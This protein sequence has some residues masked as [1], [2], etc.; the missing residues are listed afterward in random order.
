M[1]VFENRGLTGGQFALSRSFNAF[2]DY[3]KYVGGTTIAAAD[4][5]GDSDGNGKA[6]IIVG[7]GSGMHGLVRIFDVTANQKRYTPIGQ[8]AD[9]NRKFTGGLNVAVGDV[10][11]DAIPDI[12]TGTGPRGGSQVRVY[13][14]KAGAGHA[15]LSTFRAFE[16]ASVATAVRVL[17]KDIDGDGLAEI[18][19]AKGPDRN[20]ACQVKRF[21]GLSG[22]MVDA[23]F[24]TH[25][26]FSGGGLFLG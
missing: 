8:I 5:D 19:A 11:G 14:G 21:K 23:F 20:P 25:P 17:A 12:I 16:D 18:L 4:L 13:D 6:D 1:K 3:R 26:D 22:N 10:S 24:A 15:L 9:P 2:A 7:S